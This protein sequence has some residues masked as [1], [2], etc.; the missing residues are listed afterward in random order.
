MGGQTKSDIY[1]CM[2]ENNTWAPFQIVFSGIRISIKVK[3]VLRP[4][5]FYDWNLYIGMISLCTYGPLRDR[6]QY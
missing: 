4:S 2:K 1:F 5:Y 6:T 3:T